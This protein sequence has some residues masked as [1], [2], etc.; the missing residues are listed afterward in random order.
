MVVDELLPFAVGAAVV[1]LFRP[2]RRRVVPVAKAVVNGGVGIAAATVV[3]AANVVRAVIQGDASQEQA[4][5][6]KTS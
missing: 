3:G 5:P 2:A 4:Q 6:L 1:A